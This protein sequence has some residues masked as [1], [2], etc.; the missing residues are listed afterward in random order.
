MKLYTDREESR[1]PEITQFELEGWI[2]NSPFEELLGIRIKQAA[3]GQSL[4]TM[5]F[6]VKLANGGGILLG[7]RP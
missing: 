5:P 7:K 1:Q 3:D 4:L 2:D 6:T